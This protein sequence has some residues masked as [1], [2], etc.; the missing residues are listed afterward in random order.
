[1]SSAV[2]EGL[3]WTAVG[4]RNT[5]NDSGICQILDVACDN[6]LDVEQE[7]SSYASSKCL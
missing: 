3:P 6:T 5:A 4:S 7:V 1:M 2:K